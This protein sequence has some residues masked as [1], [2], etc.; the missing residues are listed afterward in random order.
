M[1]DRNTHLQA[2]LLLLLRDSIRHQNLALFVAFLDVEK[3][4]D[5]ID[6]V[7]LLE[8]MRKIGI[9]EDLVQA[10]HRL[11]PFFSLEVMGALFPQEQGTFQGSPL[12]PLLCVL[13]LMDLILY[14]NGDEASAFHGSNLPWS[15]TEAS[16]LLTTA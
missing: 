2:F 15:R 14:I 3:A 5:T 8:V 13:F 7:N 11:L 10:I 12:S 9:P 1:P 6:H 4:F 16:D